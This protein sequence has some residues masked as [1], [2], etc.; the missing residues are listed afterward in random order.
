MLSLTSSVDA[1]GVASDAV[2]SGTTSS[3]GA[4]CMQQ[5]QQQQQQ[6]VSVHAIPMQGKEGQGRWGKEEFRHTR[7]FLTYWMEVRERARGRFVRDELPGRACSTVLQSTQMN[8]QEG[9]CF[10]DSCTH[11]IVMCDVIV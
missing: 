3:E 8:E 9:G 2:V 10:S 6:H 4:A 5:Q 7:R 11:Y 1:G